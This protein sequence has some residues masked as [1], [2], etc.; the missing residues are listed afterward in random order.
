LSIAKQGIFFGMGVSIILMIIAALGYISPVYGAL[1]Q[2]GLDVI[3][4]LNALRVN[5]VKIV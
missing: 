3:I 1:L 2:E 4:I 5:F